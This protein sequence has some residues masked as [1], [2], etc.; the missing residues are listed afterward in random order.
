MWR[1]LL[2]TIV[3]AAANVVVHAFGTYAMLHWLLRAAK[4]RNVWNLAR[5]LWTLLRFIAGLLI[6]HSLEVATWAQFYLWQRCFPDRET[7]YYYSLVSYTTVG[8][9]D[10]VL[11]HSWGLMGG[12]EAMVGVLLF[13]WST[14]C[15]VAFIYYVQNH[16]MKKHLG[17]ALE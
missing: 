11:A 12:F 2:A 16:E 14:A 10:I 5:V 3:L 9:G 15:L 1:E 13:G 17:P 7:A 6:L 8:Y 4:H